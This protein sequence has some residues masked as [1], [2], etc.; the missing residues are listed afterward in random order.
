[1]LL[2]VSQFFA[3]PGDGSNKAFSDNCQRALVPLSLKTATAARCF[4]IF[5]IVFFPRTTKMEMNRKTVSEARLFFEF[6][7]WCLQILK[8]GS[9]LVPGAVVGRRV[10]TWVH[11][12]IDQ[13]VQ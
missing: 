6:S 8:D 10:G 1:M 11:D 4:D 13:Q 2:S 9:E 5:W 3:M 7:F 12:S